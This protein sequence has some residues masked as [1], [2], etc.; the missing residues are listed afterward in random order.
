MDNLAKCLRYY[1]ADRLNND[2]GWRNVT[3]RGFGCGDTFLLSGQL[4]ILDKM[5]FS[6][7]VS[8]IVSSNLNVLLYVTILKPSP[9]SSCLMPVFL[10][11]GST[12]SWTSSEDREVHDRVV[13]CICIM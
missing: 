4:R 7:L 9:R 13:F 6:L 11:R 1:I 8:A 2:P 10:V 12:R 3:V 5:L